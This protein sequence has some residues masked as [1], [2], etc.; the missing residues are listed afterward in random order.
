MYNFIN[1]RNIR[2]LEISNKS[3][4]YGKYSVSFNNNNNNNNNNNS[5]P[6][7][8]FHRNNNY[9][10]T[11]RESPIKAQSLNIK[12]NI[13]ENPIKKINKSKEDKKNIVNKNCVKIKD[14]KNKYKKI[15][16]D[17]NTN[18]NKSIIKSNDNIKNNINKSNKIII[19]E[20]Q[21]KIK[22]GKKGFKTPENSII[23]EKD[24][25]IDYLLDT[26]SKSKN[27]KEG[28]VNNINDIKINK[29]DIQKPKEENMK[30]TLLKNNNNGN[31][32][33]IPE[34]NK[35]KVFIGNIE[36][37]KDII[38]RDK[39][40][41]NTNTNKY[42][43]TLNLFDDTTFDKN[44]NNESKKINKKSLLNI[45]DNN[46]SA[47][48]NYN[49]LNNNNNFISDSEIK[50]FINFIENKTETENLSNSL[51]KKNKK[52]EKYKYSDL[53]PYHINKISFT[54]INDDKNNDKFIFKQN[55]NNENILLYNL[56]QNDKKNIGDK[57]KVDI[58]EEYFIQKDILIKNIN[59]FNLRTSINQNKKNKILFND[60][61]DNTKVNYNYL[62][63]NTCNINIEYNDK[64]CLIF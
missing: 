9:L 62:I 43:N 12:K 25:Y 55:Y 17:Q 14:F 45:N 35:S 47:I 50:S 19:K 36:G 49:Y 39:R 31:E 11:T 63:Q 6:N 13:K 41:N 3:S 22:I 48:Y 1:K 27:K 44:K 51:L 18:N 61:K 26:Y 5:I 15:N 34:I 33:S 16:K 38:E 58:N 52:N 64:K 28:I 32:E 23:I 21:N 20:N 54:K 42:D 29:Y 8:I 7:K 40:N 57:K 37:Y 60:K 2:N 53:L 59:F 24:S 10:F 30:F 56:K 4:F 46:Y